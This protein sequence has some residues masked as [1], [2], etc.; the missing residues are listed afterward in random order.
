MPN[1]QTPQAQGQSPQAINQ[2]QRQLVLSQAVEMRQ[3]IYSGTVSPGS[4]PQLFVQPRNVG[5]IKR[6][7]VEV[8]AT[9]TNG[10]TA[11]ATLTDFALSNL[12]SN[13]TFVDLANNT[14]INTS[15][16]HL[17]LLAQ[18]KRRHP[19]AATAAFNDE[20]LAF[21]PASRSQMFNVPPAS[22]PVFVAPDT[23]AASTAA[24]VRGVFEVPITYSD[25]DLR[26]GIYANVINAT[27]Q[28]GL[29]F[30][31][32]AFAGVSPADFTNAVF[33]GSPGV[34]S[35]ATV[36]VYQEYLDQL[37]FNQKTGGVVLPA[38]DLATIYELKQSTFTAITPGN[39][40]PIP[41]ANF[42]DF[43]ST[44]VIYNHDG[45]DAG[46][47]YGTDINYLALQSANFTNLWKESPLQHTLLT[48][49]MLAGDLPAGAYYMSH[50]RKP[51]S[52]TQYGNMELVINASVANAGANAQVYWED[53]AL[54]NTLP[55]AGSLASN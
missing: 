54:V 30:N 19:Y 7:V 43:Y 44:F 22:W 53:M 50:R 25:D 5:L 39:D 33:K 21:T 45:T 18:A 55:Q 46:R 3:L 31:T 28:L 52:T 49:G 26:G 14:R 2:M 29:T 23:L 4:N 13:V 37:P 36:N 32:A 15:G 20:N 9:L 41:F 42:R 35:S 34:F 17:T 27:M 40:Y 51:I 8:I 12:L 47:V 11:S 24:T 6:F 1:V 10:A 38:L 48:R 16:S